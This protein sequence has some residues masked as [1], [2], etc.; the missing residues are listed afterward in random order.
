M[1]GPPWPFS[2]DLVKQLI[3]RA[4]ILLGERAPN[5]ARVDEVLAGLA[6]LSPRDLVRFDEQSRSWIS[7]LDTRKIPL[8][9][10]TPSDDDDRGVWASLTR[11]R[12]PA[13]AEPS[14]AAL[15]LWHVLGAVA[16]DGYERERA[17][18]AAPLTILSVRLLAIRCIDWVQQVRDAALSRLDECPHELLVE[19][20]PLVTQLATERVRGQVLDALLD[21]RLSDDDLRRAYATDD[22]RSRRAAWQRLAARGTARP[23]E[24]F[25][26]ASADDDVLVRAVAADALPGLS[27]EWKRRLAERLVTDPVGWIAVQALAVLIEIDGAEAVVPALTARTAALRRAARDWASIKGVD[28]RSIYLGRLEERPNDAVALIALAEMADAQDADLFVEMLDDPRSRVRAA[29][30]RAL[31]RVDRP[32]G[33]RAAIEALET[34]AAGRVMWAAA[35]VLGDGVPSNAENAVLA[36]VALDPSQSAGQRFRALSLLRPSR[37]LHLAVL[38]EAHEQEKDEGAR[39]RLRAEIMGWS[40]TRITR[41]PNPEIRA[42]I[43]RLLPMVDAEKRRW[44]EFVLRTSA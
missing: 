32:T 6:V 7:G 24:L 44:I 2:E 40:G 17:V 26:A 25:D 3:D 20:L 14:P 27:A 38:L 31:A 19:A 34:G 16:S 9:R 35:Q 1:N 12:P 22:P 33:R 10:G 8:L 37:W 21:A 42:R 36:R 13:P 39:R 5:P 41:A 30:L 4:N 23:E 18:R 29:G 11:R 15:A 28:A 43:D